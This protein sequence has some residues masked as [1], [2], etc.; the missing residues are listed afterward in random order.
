MSFVDAF[1]FALTSLRFSRLRTYLTALGVAVGIASVVLLTSLGNGVKRYML[2]EF[3]QFGTHIIAI[4]P[5]KINT[6]GF[7]ESV[8][9][10]MRPLTLEDARS[11]RRLPFIRTAVP[12]VQGNSPVRHGHRVRWT[13]VLGANHD[14]PETWKL[15]VARGSFLPEEPPGQAR[16]LAVI[17]HK[18][19]TE[20]FPH[21][22]PLGKFIRINTERYR[23]I[24]IMERKGQMMGFDLDDTVYI[25]ANRALALY[26]REGLM[27]VD[28]LYDVN[29]PEKQVIAQVRRH[30]LAR[31]GREDFSIVSQSDMLSTLNTILELLTAVVAGIGAISLLVGGVG[32]FT[33]MS[34]AV[35]ERIHEVGLLRA[36]GASRA[37]VSFLFLLEAAILSGLGGIAGMVLGFGLGFLVHFAVPSIP[38]TI[39]WEY[40][41]LALL[42]AVATGVLAGIFPARR[43]AALPPV[44]ALRSE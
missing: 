18:I 29:R 24:G 37:Q 3:S 2:T 43:A 5:G 16:N 19:Q 12:Y 33:I 7:S 23:V 27:E 11:I 13:N 42:I 25:P 14:V 40:V 15:H 9:D 38:V 41:A 10:T 17:G 22:S 31:H 21:T 30:L 35:N 6:F 1:A 39:A 20:L 4:A 28:V 26:N 8:F 36:L 44:E 34:I 32:I